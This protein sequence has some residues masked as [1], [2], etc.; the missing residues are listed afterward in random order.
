MGHNEE[1]IEM[2]LTLEKKHK[3]AKEKEAIKE[4]KA[5]KVPTSVGPIVEATRKCLVPPQAIK[6]KLHERCT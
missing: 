6:K 4:Y 2:A 3:H 1:E 5:K